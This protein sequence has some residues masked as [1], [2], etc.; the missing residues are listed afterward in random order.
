MLKIENLDVFYSSI[1]ALHRV[2]LEVQAG[3]II[4]LI[5]ANGAGKS[6]LLNCIAGL[7][8][9]KSGQ[10]SWMSRKIHQ[11]QNNQV[12]SLEPHNVVG[13]GLALV[14]EG[15][16]IF[17]NLSV[18]ENLEMGGYTL[19]NKKLLQ[20]RMENK[21]ELFPRLAER[22]KQRAGSLS[23]G[24]QQM[25]CIARA[26]MTEP[27]LLLLDEPSLGLAPLIV[28]NIIEAIVNIN[29]K[30]G[31]TVLLVEQN[32]RLALQNSQ[33]AYV[34]ENGRMGLQ[35]QAAKLLEDPRVIQ[36]YLGA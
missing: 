18:Q 14:P 26:L 30:D 33:Y 13:L 36:A 32:A 25:L 4:S 5:G 20:Q 16:R 11:S 10:V 35:G 15:R 21:Y 3:K 28:E 2:S 1:Q 6:T 34:L 12:K 19:R 9:P 22:S 29:R 17:A 7:L 27:Q 24:E 23:G 31:I 8:R